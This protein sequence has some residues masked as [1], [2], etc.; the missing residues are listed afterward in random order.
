[1][2]NVHKCIL[3][4]TIISDIRLPISPWS[5][6]KE[7]QQRASLILLNKECERKTD[8]EKEFY[9]TKQA[10]LVK[11]L[12]IQLATVSGIFNIS[13]N[14]TLSSYK[15]FYICWWL[16]LCHGTKLERFNH[17]S[18]FCP[19]DNLFYSEIRIFYLHNEQKLKR[20]N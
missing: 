14:Q 13:R 4:K 10:L 5:W 2:L 20:W 17:C 7:K 15:I 8:L 18:L 6:T 11:K 3:S 19:I 12:Q 1:M 9:M 16:K